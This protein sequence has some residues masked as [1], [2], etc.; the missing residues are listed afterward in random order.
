M[1]RAGT[2]PTVRAAWA[3]GKVEPIDPLPSLSL[4]LKWEG[5]FFMG[6]GVLQWL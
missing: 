4:K 2:G 6:I 1:F 3:P 5:P